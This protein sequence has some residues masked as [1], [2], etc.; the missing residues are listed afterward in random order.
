M[1]RTYRNR[2][3]RRRGYGRRRTY[4]RR[5]AT[6]TDRNSFCLSM[7]TQIVYNFDENSTIGVP[8]RVVN[9]GVTRINSNTSQG[10]SVLDTDKYAV[11]GDL[12]DQVRL[13][14]M[15]VSLSYI[16]NNGTSGETLSMVNAIDRT[17]SGDELRTKLPGS[18]TTSEDYAKMVTSAS[19]AKRVTLIGG[20][21]INNYVYARSIQERSFLNAD[22]FS[23][24]TNNHLTDLNSNAMNYFNP[25]I[26]SVI[27]R[28]T[29]STAATNVILNAEIKFY[30]EFKNSI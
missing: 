27:L 10:I 21:K 4:R 28:S 23:N 20:R 14:S 3:Y 11:L 5:Y 12:Y 2:Y 6:G 29:T 8:E 26:Y 18:T 30:V 24:A 15:R 9:F 17:S 1:A 25:A 19:S 22:T 16:T 13:K 7:N